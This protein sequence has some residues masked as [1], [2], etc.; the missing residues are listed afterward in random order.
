MRD[1]GDDAGAIERPLERGARLRIRVEGGLERAEALAH[2]AQ[3]LEHPRTVADVDRMEFGRCQCSFVQLGR[4]DVGEAG[5]RPIGG[6]DRVAPGALAVAGL[7]EMERENRR[8]LLRA[9]AGA[10]LEREPDPAVDLAP[11][12][13][14]EPGVG[15]LA[16]KVVP[17][18]ELAVV[19][20]LHELGERLPPLG[21]MRLRH[22]VGEDLAD[23]V[24]RGTPARR[25]PRSGAASRS[26]GA[27]VSIRVVS[28]VSTDSGR[29]PV[30]PA[31]AAATSS[32]RK[33][34]LPR[35]AEGDVLDRLLRERVLGSYRQRQLRRAVDVERSELEPLA[36]TTSLDQ[37]IRGRAAS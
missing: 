1:P 22:L 13:V 25:R 33:S 32:R 34:G 16:Q 27:S 20:L 28:N 19:G 4:H 6:C 23:Q 24:E 7:E 21:V 35:G 3:G 14:R 18:G 11:P 5:R 17:E 36:R 30:S 9:V 10:P 12:P 37:G 8:L 15:G 31:C 29:S 2:V 26:A